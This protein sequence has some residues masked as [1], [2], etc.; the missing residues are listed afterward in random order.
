VVIT[1]WALLALAAAGYHRRD[2]AP[3]AAAAAA[4]LRAQAR[5]Q[6]PRMHL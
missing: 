4:L 2:R 6:E 3:L 1:A 5:A